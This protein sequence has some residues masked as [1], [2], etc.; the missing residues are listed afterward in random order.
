[1]QLRPYQETSVVA[2]LNAMAQGRRHLV[3]APTGSGKSEIASAVMRNAERPL[4]LVHTRVLLDQTQ[5]RIPFATVATIQ[6]LLDNGG[7]A[8]SRRRSLA[9]EHDMV[10]IDEAHHCVSDEFREVVSLLAGK[11]LFGCTATPERLDGTPLGDVFDSLH[12]A[13]KY[14]ELIALGY[15]VPCDIDRPSIDR[16][17]QKKEKIRP[18]GVSAYLARGRAQDGSWRPG[19]HFESTISLCSEAV[20][21]YAAA[22]V[23]AAL[24]CESTGARERQTL[25][26]G[27]TAGE[28]DMLCSPQALAEGFDSPRAEVCVLRRSCAGTGLYLQTVGRVL[29]PHPGKTRALLIDLCD[30]ASVHG[31]PT[32]DRSYSLD[33]QAISTGVA[34]AEPAEELDE[35]AAVRQYREVQA[36]YSRVRDS[37]MDRLRDL[38]QRAQESGYKPGWVYHQYRHQTQLELPRIYP[39]KYRSVCACCRK[40]VQLGDKVMWQ[41]PRESAAKGTVY[42]PDCW[43]QSLSDGVVHT[44]GDRIGLSVPH[45][46]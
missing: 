30:A 29:R 46:S 28:L 21:R 2:A 39:A 31:P 6:S 41:A 22:G 14:S 1:M 34:A 15:L 12:A 19:I 4:A 27:Y 20:E 5:R 3:V 11:R 42:H 43:M 38:E 8:A 24:V 23:R 7:Q 37:L 25:F 45:A 44:A 36:H 32:I 13:A 17:T 26:A 10:W 9:A 16:K 35:P 33:G 40:R 18:D